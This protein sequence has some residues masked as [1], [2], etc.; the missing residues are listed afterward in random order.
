M[1]DI[2]DSAY[3]HYLNILTTDDSTP[4]KLLLD[5]IFAVAF[6]YQFVDVF[7]DE[8]ANKLALDETLWGITG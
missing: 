7:E 8:G 5:I 6:E 1:S 2:L 3:H 4:C